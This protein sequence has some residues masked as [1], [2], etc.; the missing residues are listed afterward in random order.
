MNEINVRHIDKRSIAARVVE[1]GAHFKL[2]KLLEDGLTDYTPEVV[3]RIEQIAHLSEQLAEDAY[4]LAADLRNESMEKA[5][6]AGAIVGLM[7]GNAT[8]KGN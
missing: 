4:N 7:I 8:Q 5:G 3:S 1:L 6:Q 2:I